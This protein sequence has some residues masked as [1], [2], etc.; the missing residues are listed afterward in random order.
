M[1]YVY[2][3]KVLW[4]SWVSCFI[5]DTNIL[6]HGTLWTCSTP[7]CS[8]IYLLL[9]PTPFFSDIPLLSLP[10]PSFLFDSPGPTQSISA[11]MCSQ[12]QWPCHIQGTVPH[13]TSPHV[14]VPVVFSILSPIFIGPWRSWCTCTGFCVLRSLLF[15]VLRPDV[16]PGFDPRLL[17]SFLR[18]RDAL[19]YGKVHF[20]FPCES[21]FLPS[22]DRRVVYGS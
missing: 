13:H 1:L 9:P 4:E 18:L 21:V 12:L 10:Y 5:F 3:C 8:F 2:C 17:L 16:T 6:V 14:F 11:C 15:S 22:K 20:S 7:P 19:F